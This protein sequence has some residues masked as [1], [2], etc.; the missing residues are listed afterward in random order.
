MGAP[1]VRASAQQLVA[2]RADVVGQPHAPSARVEPAHQPAA[3]RRDAGRAAVGVAALRLDAADRPSS[4]RARRS[5]C[6]SRARTRTAPPPGSPSLPGADEHDPLVQAVLGE[7]GVH[8]ANACLN[9]SATW[10]ANTSGAAPVPPS[11]PSMVTKSSPGPVAAIAPGQVAQNSCS[12]TADL[13]PTGRPVASASSS[14]EV[15]QAV[16]VVER[17]VARRAEAV[18][19]RRHAA[20]GGDLRGHLRRRQHAAD[21]RAW[22]PGSA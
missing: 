18:A 2:Q 22:R 19:P 10:S 11:P 21:A 12:P 14:H 4:P 7:G 17:R 6:R 9:G 20:D 8:A 1:H 5:P 15:Q 3:L 13:M 16:H